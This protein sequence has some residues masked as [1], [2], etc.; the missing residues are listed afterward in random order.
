MLYNSVEERNMA[1]NE[2]ITKSN[3]IVRGTINEMTAKQ[4]NLMANLLAKLVYKSEVKFIDKTEMSLSEITEI[5]ELSKGG[6]QYTELS[7]CLVTFG[8]NASIGIPYINEKS[9]TTEFDWI[10]FFKKISFRDNK[11]T[12]LWNDEMKPYLQPLKENYTAYLLGNYL[13]LKS[14]YAKDLYEQLK[15]YEFMNHRVFTMDEL[16]TVLNLKDKY[17][18]NNAFMV[19]INRAVDEINDKTDLTVIMKKKYITKDRSR[20]LNAIDFLISSKQKLIEYWGC[21]LTE[22]QCSFIVEKIH[23]KDILVQVGKM[24]K[25]KPDI[26]KKYKHTYHNDYDIIMHLVDEDNEKKEFLNSFPNFY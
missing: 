20:H 4:K 22:E 7:K 8:K 2:V 16:R 17:N 11:L 1:K 5:M 25:D 12:F 10:P 3:K 6:R 13:N 21:Y 18:S 26:Y 15:S 23:R 24:K 19:C 9:S 14:I